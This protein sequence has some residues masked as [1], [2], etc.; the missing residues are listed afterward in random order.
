[1]SN[2][3]NGCR[4][5]AC[6]WPT[7]LIVS[8]RIVD[9]WCVLCSCAVAGRRCALHPGPLLFGG[10]ALA[11]RHLCG[12]GR[13][14]PRAYISSVQIL[15]RPSEH[16]CVAVHS[17]RP[18][19]AVAY[20]VNVPKTPQAGPVA[21]ACNRPGGLLPMDT[22]Q[23]SALVFFSVLML[24]CALRLMPYWGGGTVTRSTRRCGR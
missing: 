17:D 6:S 23:A 14:A 10:Q 15:P 12:R 9:E 22:C 4:S 5:G 2:L 24:P 1:M 20:E 18:F 7:S 3:E 8:V 21:G 11:S 16:T 19:V 13:G